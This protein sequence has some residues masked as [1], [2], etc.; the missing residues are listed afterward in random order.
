MLLRAVFAGWLIALMVWLLPAADS[1][2]IWVIIIISYLV[3]LG[4]FPHIVAG[5]TETFYLVMRGEEPLAEFIVSFILPTLLG[6][7]LGGVPLVAALAHAQV[8]MD[9]GKSRR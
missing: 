8:E 1:A 6:N 3:G 4:G 9:R 7:V 5:S 2:R